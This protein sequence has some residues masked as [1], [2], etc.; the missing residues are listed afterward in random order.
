MR[1]KL[2]WAKCTKFTGNISNFSS[3]HI[4]HT[5]D[6]LYTKLSP[7][8]IKTL[9]SKWFFFCVLVMMVFISVVY[10]FQSIWQIQRTEPKEMGKKTYTMYNKLHHWR[11]NTLK[12]SSIQR[13][14]TPKIVWQ[15]KNCCIK[16]N[17]RKKCC[18]L[19]L[20]L[21]ILCYTCENHQMLYY[22]LCESGPAILNGDRRF[23]TWSEK[24]EK[25]QHVDKLHLQHTSKMPRKNI[26]AELIECF[27]RLQCIDSL[28][29]SRWSDSGGVIPMQ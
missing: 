20:Y 10:V 8:M 9:F 23:V 6:I 3:I 1:Y 16:C 13:G 27:T 26:N 19:Y 17:I 5:E 11:W 12:T 28:S 15:P 21:Y 4:T 25:N 22:T 7:T 18:T 24:R 2:P 29:T 14:K